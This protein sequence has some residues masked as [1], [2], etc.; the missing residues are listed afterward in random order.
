MALYTEI[1]D[2]LR[3]FLESQRIFFVATAPSGPGGHVNVS[4]KG[5]DLLRVLGPATVPYADYTGSGVETIAHL[6]G[7]GRIVIMLCAFTGPP[8]IVRLHGQGEA[9][10]PQ[11]PEFAGMLG[12]LG[13]T[14]PVRSIIRVRIARISDSCGFGVPLFQFEEQRTQ[15][16]RWA[17]NKGESG[18]L[19]YQRAKNAESIDGLPGLRWVEETEDMAS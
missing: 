5:V 19:Q 17:A 9:I 10:E 4:P 11:D 8:R 3:T 15:L 6:R 13:A 18:L 12:E 2:R 7:N 1:D 16:P 14:G